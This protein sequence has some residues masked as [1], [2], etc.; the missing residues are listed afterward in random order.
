MRPTG[1]LLPA[2]AG[3]AAAHQE[4][5]SAA[6]G[7]DTLTARAQG[8]SISLVVPASPCFAPVAVNRRMTSPDHL[9]DVRHLELDFRSCNDGSGLKY[10]PG[11]AGA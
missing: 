11:G 10:S 9:Q 7:F 2:P 1:R 6:H 5:I 8:A 4:A 3:R